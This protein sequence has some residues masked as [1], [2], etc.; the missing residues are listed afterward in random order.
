LLAQR[1]PKPGSK[2]TGQ[3]GSLAAFTRID[4]SFSTLLL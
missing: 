1:L 4:N 2:T 3:V